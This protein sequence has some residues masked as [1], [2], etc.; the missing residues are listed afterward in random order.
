[1]VV[2]Q[3]LRTLQLTG[4]HESKRRRVVMVEITYFSAVVVG[5]MN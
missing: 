2:Y 3:S 4:E 1:M 5:Q